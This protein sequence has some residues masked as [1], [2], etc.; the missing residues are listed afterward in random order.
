MGGWD[1]KAMERSGGS[2]WT[3]VLWPQSGA[4]GRVAM[5]GMEML[6]SHYKAE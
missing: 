6:A 1:Y 3:P 2:A 4:K 5:E